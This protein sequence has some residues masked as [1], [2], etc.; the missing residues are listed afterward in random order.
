MCSDF[1]TFQLNVYVA[2]FNCQFFRE[3][4]R[5][6]DIHYTVSGISCGET[7]IQDVLTWHGDQC[8]AGGCGS[9]YFIPGSADFASVEKRIFP[10]VPFR[11][12]LQCRTSILPQFQKNDSIVPIGTDSAA[13]RPQKARRQTEHGS[14]APRPGVIADGQESFKY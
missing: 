12:R 3:Q 11:Y 9:R 7:Q 2:R 10:V 5:D 14:A 4:S 1:P 6:G 13:K 8:V